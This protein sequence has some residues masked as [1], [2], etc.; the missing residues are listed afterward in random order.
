MY[1][2]SVHGLQTSCTEDL[3]V[4]DLFGLYYKK[5]FMSAQH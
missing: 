5:K 2:E 1:Q 4:E 3:M